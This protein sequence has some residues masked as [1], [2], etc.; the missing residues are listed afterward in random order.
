MLAQGSTRFKPAYSETCAQSVALA[1]GRG[2]RRLQSLGL[3]LQFFQHRAASFTDGRIRLVLTNVN[4]IIPAAIAL[5]AV[6]PLY[7]HVHAAGTVSGSLLQGY[8]RDDEQVP[9]LVG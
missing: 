8:S 1:A 4:R 5:G 2:K 7:F 6:R 3:R 9:K